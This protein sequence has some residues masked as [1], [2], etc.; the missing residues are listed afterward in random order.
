MKTYE[1]N[2]IE[3]YKAQIYNLV[4]K[5]DNQDYLFKIYHYIIAKYRRN[6]KEKEEEGD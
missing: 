6:C 4:E 1:E 5:I 3:N 2:S